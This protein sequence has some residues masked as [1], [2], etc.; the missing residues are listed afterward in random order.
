VRITVREGLVLATGGRKTRPGKRR[1]GDSSVEQE[2][3]ALVQG[4]GLGAQQ[5]RT[6]VQVKEGSGTRPK[7]RKAGNSDK[8]RNIGTLAHGTEGGGTFQENL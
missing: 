5:E 7:K 4:A 6:L 1:V 8:E 3:G 2:G